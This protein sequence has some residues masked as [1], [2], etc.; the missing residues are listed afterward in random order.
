MRLEPRS[1]DTLYK[2]FFIPWCS[3]PQATQSPPSLGVANLHPEEP[4]NAWNG[5]RS[6]EHKEPTAGTAGVGEWAAQPQAYCDN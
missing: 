5:L 6:L 4:W 3:D 2:T 1:P